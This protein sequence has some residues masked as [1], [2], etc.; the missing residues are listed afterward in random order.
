MRCDGKDI[1]HLLSRLQRQLP[2]KGKP[3]S[4]FVGVG[5]RGRRPLQDWWHT[6]LIFRE[7]CG[8]SSIKIKAQNRKYKIKIIFVK[9]D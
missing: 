3:M 7:P 2:L 4:S 9:I 5:R 8:L 6:T 1:Q